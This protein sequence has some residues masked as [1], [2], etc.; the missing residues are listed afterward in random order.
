MDVDI[1]DSVDDDDV[2]LLNFL[3]DV[4][5]E[6]FLPDTEANIKHTCGLFK[7]LSSCF[8]RNHSSLAIYGPLV[9]TP[10]PT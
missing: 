2:L 8:S 10:E 3:S 5:E 4:C 6:D 1:V 9:Q 7:K